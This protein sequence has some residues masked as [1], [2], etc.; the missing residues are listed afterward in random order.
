MTSKAKMS[1]KG[2]LAQLKDTKKGKPS[3]IKEALEIYIE[4]WEKAIKNGTVSEGDDI[5][6]AL[7]KVD[8]AGGLYRAAD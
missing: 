5:D 3:Q 8:Q 6:L 1:L 2:Y 4:L 7:A